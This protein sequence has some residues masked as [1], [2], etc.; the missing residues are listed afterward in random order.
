MRYFT[1]SKGLSV[2]MTP[3]RL[4]VDGVPSCL[5]TATMGGQIHTLILL[6]SVTL[7]T[8]RSILISIGF[9]WFLGLNSSEGI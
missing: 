9:L 3:T 7:V 8:Y 5:A 1:D 2:Y 6:S 4:P